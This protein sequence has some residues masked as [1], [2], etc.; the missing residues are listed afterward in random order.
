MW[1]WLYKFFYQTQIRDPS[2]GAAPPTRL[3][4]KPNP[5]TAEQST[6]ANYITG[7]KILSQTAAVPHF[8][9]KIREVSTSQ[10][11]FYRIQ[12]AYFAMHT[13]KQL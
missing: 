7:K 12:Y 2:E 4:A 9:G 5:N 1:T 8:Q 3:P 6:N 10:I 13:Y 11:G